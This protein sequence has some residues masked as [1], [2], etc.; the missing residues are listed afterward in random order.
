M[1]TVHIDCARWLGPLRRIWTSIGYDEINLTYTPRGKAL[2]RTLRDLFEAPYF[3]RNHNALTSGNG[4][5]G[6]AWGG[7]NVYHED[8]GGAPRY[9]WGYLDRIYDTITEANGLP[10][11][12]LGFMPHDLAAEPPDGTRFGSGFEIGRGSYELGGW[13]SPPRDFR[14]WADLVHAVVR[15]CVERYGE[16]QVGRWRWEVWNEPDIPHYWLASFEEYC[17]L[18]DH[19]VRG[20][21]S[22]FPR[23]QI[24]GPATT[25]HH[26]AE[27]LDRFLAHCTEG[28]NHATGERGSR[29]DFISFHTKGAF[30]SPRRSH[31]PFVPLPEESPS[32]RVMVDDIRRSLAVIARYPILLWHQA[33]RWRETGRAT[34]DL[35]VAR[36]PFDAERVRVRHWRIDD[37]R[38]N[39]YAEW[40]RQGRPDDPSAAQIRRLKER[41]GLEL[42]EPP[43]TASLEDGRFVAHLDLPLHACSLLELTPAEDNDRS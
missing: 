22:A 36:L 6:P 34:V 30:Y 29:L 35:T 42:L 10:L 37:E 23:V 31:N 11:I 12:E 19:A 16:E 17:A 39:A 26:G 20:A 7:G 13:K 21:T 41:Q 32:T 24:G 15:H 18:Y 2:Y 9:W 33:D 1:T 43:R 3:V 4:L 40:V 5:S 38:S 25:G 27:F 14:R 8:A 28:R